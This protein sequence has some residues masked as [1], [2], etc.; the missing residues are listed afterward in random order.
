MVCWHSLTRPRTIRW[1]DT[2]LFFGWIQDH[3]LTLHKTIRWPDRGPSIDPIQDHSFNLTQDH[4]LTQHRIIHWPDTG[5]PFIDPT[6]DH[7]LTRHRTIHWPDSGT[8]SF[9]WAPTQFTWGAH[10]TSKYCRALSRM[11]Y[12]SQNV[13]HIL[14]GSCLLPS[15]LFCRSIEILDSEIQPQH[16]LTINWWVGNLLSAT[17]MVI[18]FFSLSQRL[19]LQQSSGARFSITFNENYGSHWFCRSR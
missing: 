1:P 11:C 13:R 7:S 19:Y 12:L 3:S 8:C 16:Y 14:R 18:Q 10:Q 4:S 15:S 5:L 9:F 6:Q 2:G 17:L